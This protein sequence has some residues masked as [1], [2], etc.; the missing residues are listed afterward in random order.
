MTSKSKEKIDDFCAEFGVPRNLIGEDESTGPNEFAVGENTTAVILAEDEIHDYALYLAGEMLFDNFGFIEKAPEKA[1]AV[2]DQDKMRR[3]LNAYYQI[4]ASD[5]A[6]RTMSSSSYPNELARVAVEDGVISD[7]D[8]DRYFDQDGAWLDSNAMSDL[9][10][11]YA[12]AKTEE[13][14]AHSV[15]WMLKFWKGDSNGAAADVKDVL[16]RRRLIDVNKAAPIALEWHLN[17]P[18]AGGSELEFIASSVGEMKPA[19]EF[20]AFCDDWDYVRSLSSSVS[21]EDDSDSFGLGYLDDD[22]P[23]LGL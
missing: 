11:A 1:D 10:K 22:D 2:V 4:E 3:V 9:C 14:I 6:Q 20:Y 13:N 21:D 15:T 18:D 19:G 7:E 5:L 23:F 12:R 16:E 17:R 8:L